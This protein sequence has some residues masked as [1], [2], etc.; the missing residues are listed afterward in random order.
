[1]EGGSGREIVP[2]NKNAG[3]LDSHIRSTNKIRLKD[4]APSHPKVQGQI[5]QKASSHL[6][7]I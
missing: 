2:R 4:T 3:L 7:R 6:T 1:M 5:F